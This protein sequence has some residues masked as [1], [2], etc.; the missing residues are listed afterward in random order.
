MLF[1]SRLES[2]IVRD[3]I[4]AVSDALDRSQYGP[5]IPLKPNPDGSVEINAAKLPTPTSQDRRSLYLFCRRNYQPTE[6]SV[7]D[8]PNVAHNCTR[9]TSTAVVLQSLAMLNSP[10]VFAQAERFAERVKQVAG[11]DQERRIETAFRFAL[12]RSPNVDE[13][14]GSRELL[15]KHVA[16]YQEQQKLTPERAA[17]LALQDLCQMLLNTNEFLYVQ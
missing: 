15:A 6:L 3:C 10:F 5:P 8:Q 2:E 16:R 7:F 9:R 1:R 4:L 17:D 14:S 13:V 11:A 12:C